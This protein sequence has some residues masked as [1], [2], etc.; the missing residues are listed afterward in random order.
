MTSSN[1]ACGPSA[2]SARKGWGKRPCKPTAFGPTYLFCSLPAFIFKIRNNKMHHF[3][4]FETFLPI[5]EV[6]DGLLSQAQKKVIKRSPGHKERKP[7]CVCVC[8]CVRTC[9]WC[10]LCCTC[11]QSG[12]ESPA[13][14]PGLRRSLVLVGHQGGFQPG[15][16]ALENGGCPRRRRIKGETCCHGKW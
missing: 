2:G 6:L 8:V 5:V 4:T 13:R 9:V 15:C 7:S 14:Q 11:F 3:C 16:R 12:G 10:Q 1:Q